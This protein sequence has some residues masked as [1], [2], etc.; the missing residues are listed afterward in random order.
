MTEVDVFIEISKGENIKYRYDQEKNMLVCDKVVRIDTFNYG[1]MLYPFNYGFIPNTLSK[2]GDPLDVV[3]LMSYKLIPGCMIRCKI[4]GYLDTKDDDPK[5]IVCPIEKVDPMWKDN[6]NLID[7][8]EKVNN[9]TDSEIF[10]IVNKLSDK[11]RNALI[12]LQISTN[13]FAIIKYFFQNCKD[14]KIK[15]EVGNFYDKEEALKIYQNSL[16]R[17]KSNNIQKTKITDFFE[18]I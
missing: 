15:S 9:Y 17:F 14:L 11:I 3:V 16:E 5:I 7:I 13:T 6:D 4:L 8:Y 10:S 2:D 18:R 12:S 1:F